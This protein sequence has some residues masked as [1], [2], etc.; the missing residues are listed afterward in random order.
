LIPIYTDSEEPQAFHK[1]L[2]QEIIARNPVLTIPEVEGDV[3]QTVQ[4]IIN[5]A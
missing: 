5:I 1:L 4:R 2:F 3:K